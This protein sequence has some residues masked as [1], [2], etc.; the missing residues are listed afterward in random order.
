MTII[1]KLKSN[2][3]IPYISSTSLMEEGSTVDNS[4]NLPVRLNTKL[5]ITYDRN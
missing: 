1:K 3:G 5:P 2:D 4:D